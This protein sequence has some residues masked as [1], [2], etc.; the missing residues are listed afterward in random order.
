MR[1]MRQA[2]ILMASEEMLTVFSKLEPSV[3]AQSR[4]GSKHASYSV[5]MHSHNT[6]GVLGVV[7]SAMRWS[8]SY[9]GGLFL[10][11]YG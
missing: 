6:A 10:R 8:A 2:A 7:G 4:D 3:G 5:C 9:L 1:T 11:G